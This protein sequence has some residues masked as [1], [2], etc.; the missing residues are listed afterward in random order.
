MEAM[1]GA[2]APPATETEIV[3]RPKSSRGSNRVGE[4]GKEKGIPHKNNVS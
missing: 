4:N 3:T 1:M 2:A